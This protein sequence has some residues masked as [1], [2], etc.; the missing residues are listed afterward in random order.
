MASDSAT[1]LRS[2]IQPHLS[3][4]SSCT[5]PPIP[6]VIDA[7]ETKPHLHASSTPSPL[8]E[9]R[10]IH[11][12]QELSDA[13]AAQSRLNFGLLSAR[14]SEVDRR[15]LDIASVE[16]SGIERRHR[17]RKEHVDQSFLRSLSYNTKPPSAPDRQ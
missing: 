5:M 13:A 8:L 2:S 16:G 7:L 15:A 1:A 4:I 6:V 12:P 14:G 9:L 17:W 10:G 11:D 3:S